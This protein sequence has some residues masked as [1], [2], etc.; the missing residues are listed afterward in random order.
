MHRTSPPDPM[1]HEVQ[2]QEAAKAETAI[3]GHFG[4]VAEKLSGRDFFCGKFSAAD[5]ATFMMIHYALRLGGPPLDRHPNLA[6]WYRRLAARPAFAIVIAEIAAA[7]H[8]LSYPVPA[9]RK[10]V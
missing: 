3:L 8:E 7:D 9:Y 4:S 10:P 6:A 5:I 2:E 1:R